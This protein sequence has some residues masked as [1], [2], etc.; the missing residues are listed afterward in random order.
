MPYSDPGL[1]HP[2]VSASILAL[3]VFH[4]DH[5]LPAVRVHNRF[6]GLTT[7]IFSDLFSGVSLPLG[8]L[9]PHPEPVLHHRL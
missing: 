5:V 7:L 1:P 2:C 4:R 6:G 9:G 8:T 3:C